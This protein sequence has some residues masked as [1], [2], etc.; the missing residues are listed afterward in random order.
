MSAR[1][2]RLL[3]GFIT[4]SLLLAAS[5]GVAQASETNSDDGWIESGVAS[6]YGPRH[7]GHRTSSGQRFNPNALTAAHPSLPLGSRI[8]VTVQETGR[9]VVVTV[10]DREPPHGVRCIDLSRAAAGVLGIVNR[11]T[12]MVDLSRADDATVPVEVAE[13]PEDA[14]PAPRE[15]HGRQH[16]HHASRLASRSHR[17][18]LASSES[19]ERR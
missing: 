6:W 8:R 14:A 18:Y 15:F 10:N 4:S 11:G 12:A 2:L 19:P 16:K 5:V 13:A 7:A 9:S 1:P 3:S 17:I